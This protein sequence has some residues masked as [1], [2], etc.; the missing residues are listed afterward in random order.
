MCWA[1]LTC[2]G[3]GGGVEAVAAVCAVAAGDVIVRVLGRGEGRAAVHLHKF[4]LQAQCP[5]CLHGNSASE[6]HTHTHRG[7]MVD[8][9]R[10]MKQAA[11]SQS[12]N[13]R[14]K[15]DFLGSRQTRATRGKINDSTD[16]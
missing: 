2:E 8:V 11:R 14:F 4:S 3:A 12:N 6:T 9:E 7:R 15:P 13:F 5:N 16:H 10:R 1:S